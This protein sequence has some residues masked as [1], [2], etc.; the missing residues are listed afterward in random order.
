MS[1]RIHD[2][3]R[4][5]TF[6][7][8]WRA[9][10]TGALVLA[11][12]VPVASAQLGAKA[13]FPPPEDCVVVVDEMGKVGYRISDAQMLAQEMLSAMQKRVGYSGV[14]YEGTLKSVADLQRRLGK[15]SETT[16]QADK[17]AY[18]KAA[19]KAAKYRVRIRFG[20]KKR[21][22][23]GKRHWVTVSC[24][25]AGAAVSDVLDEKTFKAKSFYAAKEAYAEAL[26]AFCP[27]IAPPQK[28]SP[29]PTEKDGPPKWKRKHK[30]KKKWTPPPLR[31]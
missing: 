26:P 5:R 31:R 15:N 25:K 20:R 16:I 3:L 29:T 13:S 12:L 22:P 2:R 17:I 30:P 7:P 4:P 9:V 14:I 8:G 10:T 27:A 19:L 11:G 18:L 23:K 28:P 21:G 6:S 1:L 24:R